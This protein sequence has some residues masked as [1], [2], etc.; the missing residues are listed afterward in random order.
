MFLII[1][2]L[3][4][5]WTAALGFGRIWYKA[6][7][8][9]RSEL[10]SADLVLAG[11]SILGFVSICLATIAP[12]RGLLG[13]AGLSVGVLFGIVEVIE[14]WRRHNWA[15]NCFSALVLVI[16][17]FY[18]AWPLAVETRLESYDTEL[19]H[20]QQVQWMGL[21]GTPLGLANLHSR[22][23]VQSS[24]LA[25]ATLIE[26]G[27]I[28]GR[29]A[30][31]MPLLFPLIGLWWSLSTIVTSLRNEDS[32]VLLVYSLVVAYSVLPQILLASPGLYHDGAAGIIQ[33]V[34]VGEVLRLVEHGGADSAKTRSVKSL[35]VLLASFCVTLKLSG[36]AIAAGAVL[37]T[38]LWRPTS[39]P[40]TAVVI[41]LVV[42]VSFFIL[43]NVMLSGWMLFP[44]PFG[45]LPLDW[46][47]PFGGFEFRDHNS[48]IQ[49]VKGHYEIIRAWARLPGPS[50]YQA[51]IGGITAWLPHW[52]ARFLGSSEWRLF[53]CSYISLIISLCCVK[54][55]RDT[56]GILLVLF[57]GFIPIGYWF[58]TA[59][60]LRFGAA[61]F[62]IL[63]GLS[64]SFVIKRIPIPS[65]AICAIGCIWILVDF[66][67]ALRRA[68]S[69]W[70]I[71][72]GEA[73]ALPVDTRTTQQGV[74]IYVPAT[75]GDDRCGNAPVPCTPYFREDLVIYKEGERYTKFK[76]GSQSH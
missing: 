36:A 35:I 16:L 11:L 26:Q 45:G 50:Y 39:K 37:L 76:V 60:D 69:P 13:I 68:G 29:S 27:A 49:T 2:A 62:V 74:S 56:V 71:S 61:S 23:G 33:M 9:N 30:W 59:P 34:L 18:F 43:R 75:P 52:V 15:K 67:S 54:S 17:L 51:A 28:V 6:S 46:A 65:W 70:T 21:H 72:S 58:I 24:F 63:F 55:L 22:L 4:I 20:L 3:A 25:I 66:S 5:A 1:T 40:A 48:S 41:F 44:A 7:D 12:L 10:V 73:V 14:V 31:F 38:F 19:Y 8:L 42:A 53:V 57:L 64:L 47:M 32:R